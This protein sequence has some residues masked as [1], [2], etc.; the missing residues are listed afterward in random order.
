MSRLS[1]FATL[2]LFARVAFQRTINRS[3]L[4][5]VYR[6]LRMSSADKGAINRT[7][8]QHRDAKQSRLKRFFGPTML[9]MMTLGWIM[10]C[11]SAVHTLFDFVRLQE[12]AANAAADRPIAVEASELADLRSAIESHDEDRLKQTVTSVFGSVPSWL[13]L[14]AETVVHE[15]I[16]SRGVSAFVAADENTG[17]RGTAALLS[18]A[19]RSQA[20]AAV[21]L[22][23]FMAYGAAIAMGIGLSSKSLTQADPSLTWLMT[24]PVSRPVLFTAKV[25]EYSLDGPTAI[26]GGSISIAL[27]WLC[28]FEFFGGAAFAFSL[29]IAAAVTAGAIRVALE[30]GLL[31]LCTRKQRGA[32]VSVLSMVGGLCLFYVMF[33]G[34]SRVTLQILPTIAAHLPTSLYWNPLS[35]G[36]GTSAQLAGLE[37]PWWLTGPIGAALLAVGAVVMSVR[38]TKH[39]L[40]SGQ[41]TVR[42]DEAIAAGNRSTIGNQ[43]TAGSSLNAGYFTGMVRKELLQVRRRPELVGQIMLAP[44]FIAFLLFMNGPDST[45][46]RA[47]QGSDA[48]CTAIFV[49]A[50][51]LLLVA[52]NQMLTGE[53]KTLWFLQCLPKS[54]GE[55]I[56]VKARVWAVVSILMIFGAI[57][58][59]LCFVPTSEWLGIL[60]RLPFMVAAVWLMAEIIFG[61]MSLAATI[62]NDQTI[63]FRRSTLFVPSILMA[64]AA[65]AVYSGDFW[66]QFVLLVVMGML[67]AA[68]RQKQEAEL[69]WLSEPAENPPSRLY[70]MHGLIAIVGFLF[71]RDFLKPMLLAAGLDAAE[72]LAIAYCGSALAIGVASWFWVRRSGFRILPVADADAPRPALLRPIAIG[73]IAT[74]SVGFFWGSLMRLTIDNH[75]AVGLN[76][77]WHADAAGSYVGPWLLIFMVVLVAPV[78][79]E[80][81]FRGLLYRSLRPSLGFVASLIGTSL[82]FTV[83]HPLTSSVTVLVL[84]LVTAWLV[85]RTN[86]LWPS[87]LVHIGYNAFVVVTWNVM[88]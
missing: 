66:S 3:S 1:S 21:G 54:I 45:I 10:F 23:L 49:G 30:I 47:V 33:M 27:A 80:W 64:T 79:E 72:M 77:T 52:V 2:R 12:L 85:E 87:M 48:I 46:A 40:A 55:S 70:A 61:L 34:N 13:T 9:V 71:F 28:G 6:K 74:C 81:I 51:Y 53:L 41:D 69:A 84:G 7:A 16:K 63:R 60:A 36:F 57:G 68:V 88:T 26:I 20:F 62:V 50:T 4:L 5:N 14:E 8:T 75:G 11:V 65:S 24:F 44:I 18:P 31:Q 37:S 56:R 78:F 73:L 29:G 15:R 43:N 67:N 22:Y 82:L 76:P 39:G 25:V 42:S 58:V 38:L 59:M 83:V 19:G 86:R 35:Q 32:C 17:W